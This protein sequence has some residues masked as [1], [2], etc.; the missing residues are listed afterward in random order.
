MVMLIHQE[1]IGSVWADC[2][3]YIEPMPA[4]EH[5]CTLVKES[6]WIASRVMSGFAA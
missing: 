1:V 5:D 6:C 4:R 2:Q 3:M